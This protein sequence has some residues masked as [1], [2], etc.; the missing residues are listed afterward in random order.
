RPDGPI[1]RY[2]VASKKVCRLA[3]ILGWAAVVIG[4]GET[5][6]GVVVFSKWRREGAWW[7]GL[8]AAVLGIVAT[9][10]TADTPV[11]TPLVAWLLGLSLVSLLTSLIALFMLD[12]ARWLH[13]MDLE[14]CADTFSAVCES[15]D[16][17][18]S[19][20]AGLW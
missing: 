12:G 19:A 15:S 4:A 14:D 7:A 8:L 18:C 17:T 3:G 9:G 16:C 13:T 1:E 10:I 11:G 20:S 6:V 2:R 5:V